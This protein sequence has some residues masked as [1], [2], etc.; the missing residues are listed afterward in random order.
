MITITKDQLR[1]M[2]P[3]DLSERLK[4]FGSAEKMD[5]EAALNAGFSIS[6]VLWVA[7]QLGL[8]EH[9]VRFAL[10][11]AQRVAKNNPDERVAT[12]LRAAQDWIDNPCPRTVASAASAAWAAWGA[13]SAESA[14]W[15]AWASA[16]AAAWAAESAAWAAEI[17]AQKALLISIFGEEQ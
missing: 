2:R 15:A 17:E 1:E 11:S 4:Q 10:L 7:G 13:R 9:C 16:E 12:A 5:V 14:A 8:K 6:N 3:C